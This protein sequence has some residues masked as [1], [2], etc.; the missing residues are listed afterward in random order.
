M[1]IFSAL[2]GAFIISFLPIG[3]LIF[4]PGLLRSKQRTCDG[5]SAPNGTLLSL[6][7]CFAA[8]SLVGDALLNLLAESMLGDFPSYEHFRRQTM[9]AVVGI[10]V[11]YIID[12]VTRLLNPNSCK[13]EGYGGHAIGP[14]RSSLL[15]TPVIALAGPTVDSELFRRRPASS[16]GLCM[17]STGRK[18]NSPERTPTGKKIRSSGILSL[19]ADAIHNFTDGLAL[20]ASFSRDFKLGLSTTTAI[21]FHEVPHELGDYAILS[22]AGFGHNEIIF[23]QIATAGSAFLGVFA[24]WAIQ[25]QWIPSFG[26]LREESLLPFASGGF[27]YVALCSILPEANEEGEAMSL[28]AVILRSSAFWSGILLISL[29]H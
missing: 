4:V 5:N 17:L 8:G 27:L 1:P 20:F 26:V 14:Q 6:M 10:G 24:G 15:H 7:L 9:G 18:S 22:K 23:T 2:V 16:P 19:V 28:K 12:A 11:F 25:R 21:F 13:I 3:L 29:L